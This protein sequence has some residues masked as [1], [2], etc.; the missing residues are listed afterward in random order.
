MSEA[1]AE[2]LFVLGVVIFQIHTHVRLR[3][4]ETR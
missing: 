4:L 2:A 1:V 3:R